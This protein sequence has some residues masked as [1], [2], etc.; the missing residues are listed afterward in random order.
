LRGTPPPRGTG[1][2]LRAGRGAPEAVSEAKGDAPPEASH[3]KALPAT[4]AVLPT[5]HRGR[6]APTML[7]LSQCE[8]SR[9]LTQGAYPA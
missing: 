6:V 8:G 1:F 9:A 5:A 2:P 4:E 3:R 7:D